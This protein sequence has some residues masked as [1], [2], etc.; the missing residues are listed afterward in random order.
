[1]M[2]GDAVKSY[3]SRSTPAGNLSD[4]ENFLRSLDK[5]GRLTAQ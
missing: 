1:M 5:Q 3:R 4:S 2:S